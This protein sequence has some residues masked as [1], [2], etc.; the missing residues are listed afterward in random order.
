MQEYP[1]GRIGG[2]RLSAQRSAIIAA[3]VLWVVCGAGAALL[4]APLLEAV[5]LGLV[6]MLLHW[7]SEIWHQG[8]H[9]LVARRLGHP[10]IGIRLWGPLSASIYPAD[11]PSLPGPLHVQRAL[12]GP[13]A[14]AVLTLISGL[15]V[16]LLP[17]GGLVT[18]LA[19]FV[20]AENL[21]VFTLGSLLPLG[22]NDGSSLLHW[23]GKP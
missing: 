13:A 11:E 12:G 8:G 17:W 19:L 4:G 2:L 15:V 23:W 20:F 1:L 21:L 22:F 5:G 16:L 6:A 18:G 9:A 7:A 14:S 3:G 10:M